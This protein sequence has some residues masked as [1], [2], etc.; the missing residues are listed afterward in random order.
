[1]KAFLRGFTSIVKLFPSRN[2][3]KLK[4]KRKSD[5]ENIKNDW[6]KIVNW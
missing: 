3:S 5:A 1:M 4:L 6:K 2:P